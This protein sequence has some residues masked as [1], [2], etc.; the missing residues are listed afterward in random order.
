MWHYVTEDKKAI[1]HKKNYY[2]E[3]YANLKTTKT[4]PKMR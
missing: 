3:A 1:G 4:F 2:T